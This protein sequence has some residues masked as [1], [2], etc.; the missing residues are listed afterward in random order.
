MN[1][2]AAKSELPL[3]EV[4]YV[5]PTHRRPKRGMAVL[6]GALAR[7]WGSYR[8]EASLMH[9]RGDMLKDVGL[10]QAEIEHWISGRPYL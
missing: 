2:G 3:I 4:I 6:R 5:A 1:S 10:T 8:S 9:A 7:W